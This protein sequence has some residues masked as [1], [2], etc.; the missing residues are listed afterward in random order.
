MNTVYTYKIC[1]T[2]YESP[3]HMIKNKNKLL[4]YKL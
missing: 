3:G 1:N 4:A 2:E